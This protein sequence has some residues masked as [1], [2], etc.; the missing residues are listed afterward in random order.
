L[1]RLRHNTAFFLFFKIGHSVS[2]L[3]AEPKSKACRAPPARPCARRPQLP[4]SWGRFFWS[5]VLTARRPEAISRA[6]THNAAK[7]EYA[8]LRIKLGTEI[9][10]EDMTAQAV[11]SFM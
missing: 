1:W 4:P 7:A 9:P 6:E 3:I 2:G 8:A 5:A 10:S 11:P